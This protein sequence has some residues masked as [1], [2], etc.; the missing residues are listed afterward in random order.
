MHN[1]GAEA[2]G[3]SGAQVVV[4]GIRLGKQSLTTVQDLEV[5]LDAAVHINR[6]LNRELQS[7]SEQLNKAEADRHAWEAHAKRLAMQLAQHKLQAAEAGQPSP[8]DKQQR[9]HKQQQLAARLAQLPSSNGH[10]KADSTQ[11]QEQ[12]QPQIPQQPTDA[13]A[14]QAWQLRHDELTQLQQKGRAGGW[15]IS[16]D[17]IQLQDVLGK[18]AFGTTFRAN[19]R[20][21]EVAVKVVQIGSHTELLNFLREIEALANLRH[22]NVVPFC[23]AVLEES[24]RKCWL[25]SEIMTGGTLAHWL[26][27]DKGPLGPNKTLL[28]RVQKALEVCRGLA[29][30]ESCSPPV[31]HRDVKPSNVFVDAAGVARLGDFGLSRAMP[32]NSAALTGETGTYLYMSPEMIRHEVYDGK[33]DVWSFGVLLSELLTGQVPYQHTFMTPVQI[34]MGVADEKLQPA[35]PSSDLLP[36]LVAI[37]TLCCDFDPAMR[38]DFVMVAAEL[39]KVVKRMQSDA[40][41]APGLFSIWSRNSLGI[42]SS[43]SQVFGSLAGT[44]SS[45]STGSS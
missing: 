37:A 20:G 6:H 45:E 7:L 13:D 16:T 18:G 15:L 41:A 4:Q 26:H 39:E 19:W 23:A 44:S 10:S 1:P 42:P 27:G 35:L 30:L 43:W 33:T 22:P 2:N 3:G 11:Q 17:E 36:D 34:A 29:A 8:D 25:V 31:L 38:P 40:A 9:E 32:D 21:A 12:E 14:V 24:E 5:A 28:Q